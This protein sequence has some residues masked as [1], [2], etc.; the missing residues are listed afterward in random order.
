MSSDCF[1]ASRTGCDPADLFERFELCHKKGESRW[2]SS[3][4]RKRFTATSPASFD[5]VWRTK[6]LRTDLIPV[7]KVLTSQVSDG[8]AIGP[9]C[10]S[11]RLDAASS[12]GSCASS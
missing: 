11:R 4:M 12:E 6:T 8:Q 1:G 2:L 7:K 3:L 9:A 5:E 10:R